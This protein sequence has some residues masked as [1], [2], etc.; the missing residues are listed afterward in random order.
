[1]YPKDSPNQPHH[2]GA[3]IFFA[4]DGEIIACSQRDEIRDE[5][6]ITEI[7]I[8]LGGGER[9]FGELD[10]PLGFELVATKPLLDQMVRRHYR[11]KRD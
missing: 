8:L 9:L 6:I 11:R 5:M 10:A 2:C 1:M 3:A 4:P 7:P